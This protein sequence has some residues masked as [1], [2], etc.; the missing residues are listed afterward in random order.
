MNTFT[1]TNT[2]KRLASMA[3]AKNIHTCS[4]CGKVT[5]GN[6]GQSSHRL[7]HVREAGLDPLDFLTTLSAFIAAREVLLEA[8]QPEETDG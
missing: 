4:L 7:K 2:G 5:R 6:G 3:H 1:H 8:K